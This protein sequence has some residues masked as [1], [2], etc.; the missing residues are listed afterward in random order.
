LNQI[1]PGESRSLPSGHTDNP[2]EELFGEVISSYTD[3][4][5]VEDGFLVALTGPG[6]INRVTRAVFDHFTQ[7]MGVGVLD[8]F[9]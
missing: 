1:P 6:G 5:A 9:E 3:R 2:S 8:F 7:S 4:E